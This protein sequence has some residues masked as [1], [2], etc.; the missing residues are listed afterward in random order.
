MISAELEK[1]LIGLRKAARQL[2]RMSSEDKNRYLNL[3]ADRILKKKDEILAANRVDLARL[4]SDPSPSAAKS[5]HAFKDRMTL[6]SARIDQMA[7]SI[8]AV[9]RLPDPVGEVIESRVLKNGLRT[10]RVRAPLG[11]ILMIFESRPN[12]TGGLHSPYRGCRHPK[13]AIRLR[14]RGGSADQAER[15]SRKGVRQLLQTPRMVRVCHDS[16]R[17]FSAVRCCFGGETPQAERGS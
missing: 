12:E 4:A 5:T 11:A 2:R 16:F 15:S 3:V 1:N 14:T 9:S 7:E 10:R 17:E 13:A 8:R 6:D